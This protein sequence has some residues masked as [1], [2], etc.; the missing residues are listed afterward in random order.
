MDYEYDDNHANGEDDDDI[1]IILDPLD[2]DIQD[3][4]IFEIC[5][6]ITLLYFFVLIYFKEDSALLF[7]TDRTEIENLELYYELL[8]VV[9]INSLNQ[10]SNFFSSHPIYKYKID[11]YLYEIKGDS[12]SQ[13]LKK[14]TKNKMGQY[15]IIDLRPYSFS[16][17]EKICFYLSHSLLFFL[18]HKYTNIYFD[19]FLCASYS[20]PVL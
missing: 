19:F 11:L 4:F 10:T 17:V 14:M 20:Q 1:E 12:Y 6:I 5:N 7:G 8:A 2:L 9:W 3:K 13:P 15:K 18:T 16:C